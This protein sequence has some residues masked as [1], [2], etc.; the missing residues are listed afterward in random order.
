MDNTNTNTREDGLGTIS[1]V[2]GS[3]RV[4]GRIKVDGRSIDVEGARDSETA[5]F[6]AASADTQFVVVGRKNP[7]ISVGDKQVPHSLVRIVDT[8]TGE[9]LFSEVAMWANPG[10]AFGL[11]SNRKAELTSEY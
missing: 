6:R 11:S 1:F 5:T 9:D 4:F 7:R 8:I 10:K 2:A 3:R